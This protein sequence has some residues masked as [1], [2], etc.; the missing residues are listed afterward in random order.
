MTATEETD[1]LVV[2]GVCKTFRSKEKR[3]VT[4]ARDVSFTLRRG[5]TIAIVGESGSG[6]STLLRMAMGLCLPDSGSIRFRGH[7]WSQM[8]PAQRRALRGQIG[9]VFQE[10]FESLDPRQH[11]REIVE[12][13]LRLHRSHYSRAEREKRVLA[14]L[15]LVG[16][17][18]GVLRKLPGEISG[19]QQQR[20]GIAR[21]IVSSPVL[22]LLDEP[23]SALDL[24]V[25]AQILSI[26]V[27]LQSELS[28]G[29]VLVT[30]DLDVASY[31]ATRL[32]VMR[33]GQIEEEGDVDD[34]LAHPKSPYARELLAARLEQPALA[35]L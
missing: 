16:L 6:K 29:V 23:T 11:V 20:V 2:D 35:G 8:A 21:A 27:N 28:V 9:M 15:D 31:L 33:Y 32:L 10:P 14:A 18:Q 22:V 19:G 3:E 30:H 7:N 12:E 4:A 13:P 1:F 26:L 5:E 24:S 25:Q 34:L 17:G